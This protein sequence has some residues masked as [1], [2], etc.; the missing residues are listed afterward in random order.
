[1]ELRNSQDIVRTL[2]EIDL[3]LF[4]FI[5]MSVTACNI[6][7]SRIQASARSTRQDYASGEEVRNSALYLGFR[8]F[9]N[10]WMWW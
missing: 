7:K 8:D 3:F 4:V 9:S 2:N 1:M 5:G 10:P 6:V